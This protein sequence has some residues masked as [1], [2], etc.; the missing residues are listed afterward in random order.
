MRE[1]FNKLLNGTND[2]LAALFFVGMIITVLMAVVL[3]YFFGFSFRWT[4]EL[5]RYLFIY[6]VFLGIPIAF[7]EKIHVTIQFFISLFSKK[8]QRLLQIFCDLSI[9]V[10]IVYIAYYTIIM[11][12]GR[13][14]TTPSSGL[15][16]QM[17]YIYASVVICIGLLMIELIQ[18]FIKGYK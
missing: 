14:G 9:F 2:V 15:K 7:R 8:I 12:M 6:M 11:I 10:T 16:I 4:D 17:G 13:L 1:K 5:T 3:R 18:R